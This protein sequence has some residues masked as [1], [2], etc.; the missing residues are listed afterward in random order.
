MVY[1]VYAGKF[2][3]KKSS[4][5]KNGPMEAKSDGIVK[6]CNFCCLCTLIFQ[7]HSDQK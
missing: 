7:I 3:R 5:P 1:N 6:F 2:P 4:L